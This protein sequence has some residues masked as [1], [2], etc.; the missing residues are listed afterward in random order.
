M[1]VKGATNLPAGRSRTAEQRSDEIYPP[2][3]VVCTAD[4]TRIC[5]SPLMRRVG[6]DLVYVS[7]HH[8]SWLRTLANRVSIIR[9]CNRSR[10]TAS[11][12]C[13]MQPS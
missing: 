10:Y 2:V 7:R 4:E 3:N 1:R 12:E 5:Q 6:A 9:R 13:E 8:Q 11:T